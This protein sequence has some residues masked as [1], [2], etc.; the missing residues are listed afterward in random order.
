MTVNGTLTDA[1][2]E[3]IWH[4]RREITAAN[5]LLDDMDQIRKQEEERGNRMSKIEPTLSDVFGR[6][7]HL[8]MGVPSGETGHRI[9]QVSPRLAESVIRAHI[10]NKTA[11][12]TEALEQAR[13]EL[14]VPIVAHQ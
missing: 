10:G 7:R 1:T 13:I 12:L 9:F 5:K 4:C 8:E 6:R 11:E 14:G 3:R 2:L